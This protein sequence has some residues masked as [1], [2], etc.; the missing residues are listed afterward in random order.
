[1]RDRT[2]LLF[3]NFVILSLSILTALRVLPG[4]D[5]IGIALAF[6]ALFILPGLLLTGLLRI[7]HRMMLE[8][9]CTIFVA[10]LLFLSIL[11]WIGLIPGFSY[12]ETAL[13]AAVLQLVMLILLYRRERRRDERSSRNTAYSERETFAAILSVRLFLFYSSSLSVS[14]FSMERV[15]PGGILTLPIISVI[16]EGASTAVRSFHM[17]PSIRGAMG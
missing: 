8:R 5:I 9:I 17:T 13:V 6:Y 4:P 3:V 7:S 11:I 14:C 15:R 12:R 10:S 2:T 16:S 1:M